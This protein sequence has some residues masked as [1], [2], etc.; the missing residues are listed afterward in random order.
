M[1]YQDADRDSSSIAVMNR[2]R[3]MFYTALST[4]V[5]MEEALRKMVKVTR[6]TAPASRAVVSALTP[7]CPETQ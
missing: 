7:T 3:V 6:G 2:L 1:A 5:F 4:A